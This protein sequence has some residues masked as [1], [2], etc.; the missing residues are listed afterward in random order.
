VASINIRIRRLEDQVSAGLV[1]L[2]DMFAS[3]PRGR[4][5]G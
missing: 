1:R 2:L 3:L 4:R 5:G